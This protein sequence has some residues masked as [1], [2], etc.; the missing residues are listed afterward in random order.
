MLKITLSVSAFLLM[1]WSTTG[2]LQKE[3]RSE[4]RNL[5]KADSLPNAAAWPAELNVTHFAGHDLTPSPACLAVAP[6]GEVF[7]GVD[8]IGS[9]G[10][11]PGKGSIVRLVDADN[12]GKVDQHTTFAM[13]DNPRGI[14]AQGDQVF[15]LHTTFS[16]E[17]GKA[18]GM[19][20]VVLED[21]NHDGVADGPAKPLVENICSPKFLQSRGTDHAT[22]GIRM[23]I[24]GWIYIAVGDFGFHD[25]LD[26]SGKKMTQLGGG[27]VRVRPDGTEME[28][29][30]H[31][32]R[33]IYDVAIDP[34]MNIFTRDNTNDGGGWN[35]RFSNQIQSG[36]YGY[37]VLFKNFTEEI[38][39]A[40][41]DLGG[42]S[43]TGSLFMDDP[44]W[45]AKYNRVPMM[46]DWGRS[47]VYVHRVTPDGPTF[48]QKE[49]EFIKLSQ[50]T[51]LDIDASGRVYLAAW[52]G[53]GYSGNPGKGFISRAVPQG[54]QYKEFKDISKSSVKQLAALLRSES[55]VQRLAAQQE[56]LK[57]PAKD[58][59]KA[60]WTVAEDKKAPLYVRVA[61][62][63]T[64]A[65]A[66]GQDGIDNLAKLASE[67]DMREHALRALADRKPYVA[68][69]PVE[70]F[71]KALENGNAREKLAAAIGLGRLGRPE[72]AAALLKVKVPGSFVAPVKG[73]EGPHATPNSAIVTPHIAVRALVALNAVD[74]CVKAIGTE[75][76]TIAL[77]ALRYM[78]DPKAV[79]GLITAYGK[80][81]D[82]V[83]KEQ[84]LTTLGRIYK[85]EADY[86]GSWWW[87]TRPDTHGPYYKAVEWESSA[88][89]KDFLTKEFNASSDKQFFA[90]LNE[91]N[92][93]GISE[94]GGEEVVAAKEEVK[95][96]LEKIRNKKGQVG[97]SSI[98]DVMLAIAKIQGDPAT[99]RKLFTKQGCVACH[100]LSRSEVMKGPFMGQIGSIMNR[101]QIAESILKPNASISQGFASV[102]ITT[103]GDKTYMGFVSEES[104]EKLVIRDITGQVNTIK[105]ANITSRKEMETSMMPP[106]LA[107]ELSYE[108][109]ASLITFL[110]QQKK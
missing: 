24:D 48:Q 14:I 16:K 27:I 55:A 80:T 63:Y 31:G 19:D 92:R 76:S 75:N 83:L 51:D 62:M 77:W 28:V 86:D 37:P 59:A 60:A 21:K 18:S 90:D 95:V 67:S 58:A 70:P 29:Y 12:D 3:E 49:E 47:Q 74:A 15:V 9:L 99:G 110:S 38:I 61:G 104:A 100:S 109:F 17:T 106:G 103:K 43:G 23:G 13:L 39:P 79:D 8:M 54:W 32:L 64:Y 69:V 97:E 84:I 4:P 5:A 93:M 40:L 73:S 72:G 25:A 41:I 105:V 89:V 107:N 1:L 91:R 96:D 2:T 81:S 50:V 42:G 68:K 53:A 35:I 36:E 44:T 57:R 65:Q 46:A 78:H 85:K 82:K 7:V 10:K 34:Y 102:M 66:S 108:E 94:F 30:T 71:L 101:E 6:T 98:E 20:L 22:N 56:L 45:P 88:K 33:N 87:S 26:R 52:D 11:T